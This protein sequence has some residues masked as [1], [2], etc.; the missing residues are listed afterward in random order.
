MKIIIS[1]LSAILL[2]PSAFALESLIVLS[3][4]GGES[5]DRYLAKVTRQDDR[6]T[7][8]TRNDIA[9]PE[10]IKNFNPDIRFPI[11]T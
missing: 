1:I 11:I 4:Q 8:K 6:I 2:A 10:A 7:I 5:I 3:D 9:V